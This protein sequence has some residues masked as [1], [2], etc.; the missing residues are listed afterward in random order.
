MA[1]QARI[2][3]FWASQVIIP[4]KFM[5]MRYGPVLSNLLEPGCGDSSGLCRPQKAEH[6][7]ELAGELARRTIFNGTTRADLG[8]PGN[9]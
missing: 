2:Q 8:D 3:D 1:S 6:F 9:Q 7:K 5:E 4:F